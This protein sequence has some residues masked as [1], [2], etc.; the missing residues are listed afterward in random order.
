MHKMENMEPLFIPKNKRIR[1]L[2]VT[3]FCNHCKTNVS[4]ICKKTGKSIKFCVHGDKHVYKQ[5]VFVPNSSVRKTKI[6]NRDMDLNEVL[7]QAFEFQKEV[8]GSVSENIANA[9]GGDN[10]VIV[11]EKKEQV[12]PKLLTHAMASYIGFLNNENVPS[13]L[14]RPRSKEY[15]AEVERAFKM[16]CTCLKENGYDVSEYEVGAINDNIVGCLHDYF[17]KVK[18]FSNRSYNK[19]M[20]FYKSWI[21]W[22]FKER[23]YSIKNYFDKVQSKAVIHNPESISK[24]EFKNLLEVITPEN[25]I[26]QT[27]GKVKETRN[28]YRSW[29]ADGFKLAVETGLR[30]ENIICLRWSDLI[31]EN[32]TALCFHVDNYKV[33][34]IQNLEGKDKRK[35]FIPVTKNLKKLLFELG[36]EQYRNTNQYVLAPEISVKR[37]RVMADNLSRGF[38]HFYQQLETGKNL[39]FKCLRKTYLTQLSIYTGGNA[40]AISGHSDNAVIEEHYVDKLVLARAAQGF[41]VFPETEEERRK[42]EIQKIRNSEIQQQTIER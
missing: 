25:G 12:Q 28:L 23:G 11:H 18:Q 27:P 4:D 2:G 21:E 22:L 20:G 42:G 29:L 30:R 16:F 26:Q 31:E 19:N 14:Q 35:I 1:G 36:Y 9:N 8:K 24:E 34:K 15:I 33:N 7:K 41:D 6:F 5:Y 38:S 10:A 17:L 37:N 13:H 3:V 39:H 32:N 40:K